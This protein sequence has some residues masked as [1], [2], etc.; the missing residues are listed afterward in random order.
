MKIKDV[1]TRDVTSVAPDATIQE[2]AVCMKTIDAGMIPVYD[3]RR[4]LGIVTDRDITVRATAEG[5]DPKTTKV[6][7]VMSK[8]VCSC[9]EDDDVNDAARL[10][11]REQI[12]RIAV[13]DGE[14]RLV[15]VVS[16]GDLALTAEAGSDLAGD[17]LE[18]VSQPGPVQH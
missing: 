8:D 10:M 13:I 7:E 17:V 11:E 6:S 9:S 16:L 4:L 1:M 2:A 14:Q 18:R 12:R 5:R 15:G 3:G